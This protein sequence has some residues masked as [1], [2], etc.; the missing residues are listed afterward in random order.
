M[1]EMKMSRNFEKFEIKKR[2]CSDLHED[3]WS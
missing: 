2:V 3:H 1:E